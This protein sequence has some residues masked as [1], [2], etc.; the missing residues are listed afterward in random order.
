MKKH[1]FSHGAAVLVSVVASS[2]LVGI[3]REH[4]PKVNRLLEKFSGGISQLIFNIFGHR[5]STTDINTVMLAM[6]LAIIWGM[7]FALIHKD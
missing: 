7:A 4:L 1:G 5:F 6:L 3:M 2:L